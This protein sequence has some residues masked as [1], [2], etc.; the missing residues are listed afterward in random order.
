MR[1]KLQHNSIAVLYRNIKDNYTTVCRETPKG[2]KF[3]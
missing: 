1:L 2:I 3:N